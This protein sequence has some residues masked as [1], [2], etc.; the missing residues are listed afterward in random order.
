MSNCY[1][2][3]KDCKY[4]KYFLADFDDEN[5]KKKTINKTKHTNT[6]QSNQNKKQHSTLVKKELPALTPPAT[7]APLK[8]WSDITREKEYYSTE[9]FPALTPPATQVS[10]PVAP[11]KQWPK[12]QNKK[13]WADTSDSED[14]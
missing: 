11:V 4:C 13:C 8:K 7:V 1:Y 12:K 2:A 3:S 6:K 5:N 10:L 9:E 14:D